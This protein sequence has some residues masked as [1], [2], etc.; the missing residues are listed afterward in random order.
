MPTMSLKKKAASASFSEVSTTL[1][2]GV[3]VNPTTQVL[4]PISERI[5][6]AYVGAIALCASSTTMTA[7]EFA[8]CVKKS[9]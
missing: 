9:A 8:R 6:A 3:A 4:G 1:R 2:P 7:V 5:A